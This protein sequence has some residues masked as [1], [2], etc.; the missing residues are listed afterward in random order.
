M[1]GRTL[2][3]YEILGPLGAGG[4]GEVYRARDERLEREVAIKV[5]PAALAGDVNRLA[6]FEREA[7]AL[8]RLSHPNILTIHDFGREHETSFA[9]MELLEG[10]TL[11]ATIRRGPLP[12]R[13]AVELAAAIAEGLAAA[14]AHGITHRDLKPD[15]LFLTS[16]GRVKILDFGLAK[17]REE[18]IA[19]VETLAPGAPVTIAG[20]ILGTVGY[21]APEQVRG[22]PADARSDI[23]AFGCVLYALVSGQRAFKGKSEADVLSAILMSD[24]S[25]LIESV[26]EV[27]APLSEIVE[28]CLAKSPQ[29][30]FQ[31][32]ED[33]AFALRSLLTPAPATA[34]L[35]SGEVRDDDENPSVAVLPF[36]NLSADPEQEYF[37]DGMAE[38]IINALAQ[39]T[40]LRVVARTSAFAFKGQAADIREIGAKLDVRTVLEGS[41]RKAGDRLRITAQL[42]N[43]TDGYHLWSER[44]DRRLEDVFEIQDEIS[45]AIVE[46]LEVKLLGKEQEAVVKRHTEN[47]DAYNAY[48]QAWFHWNELT[49]EAYQRSRECFEEAARI[50]PEYARAYS[51]LAVWYV[52]QSWWAEL[53]PHDALTAATPLVQRAL[54]LDDKISEA[55]DLYGIAHGFFR[56][57]WDAAESSLRKA[58]ELG[59]N[60]AATRANLGAFLLVKGRFDEALAEV[61]L[62]Q[63]LDP[64]SPIWNTWTC[65]WRAFAGERDE[66][67]ADL[68]KVVTMHPHHWMPHYYLS[69]LYA[70]AARLEEA[71]A[72]AETAAELSGGVSITVAQLAQVCFLGGDR[73]RGDDHFRLLQERARASYVPPTFLAWIHLARQEPDDAFEHLQEAVRGNDPW[74]VFH[75]FVA[76]V[77]QPAD[78]RIDALLDGLGL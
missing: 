65:T 35:S 42:I 6:R 22:E 7:K 40:G 16:D 78:A 73:D 67:L 11:R 69:V 23:F 52:S 72:E 36:A 74:L 64:L 1:I 2:G 54:E 39:V 12:W 51:G 46:K 47:L 28:R 61:S 32:T 5:L 4:M 21:M 77:I 33:L 20:T 38:E 60:I 8:A 58:V 31:S 66:G 17:V 37:C 57:Q 10:E 75:R 68:E 27:P 3:H 49:P 25:T 34:P 41:V 59:P 56:H 30:R 26:P 50:D 14:H 63:K 53:S 43:V 19:D 24:P 48:L 62:A 9:V 18:V 55:H 44:F 29:Q 15:N 70:Q 13:R 76:P 71:R 45:L